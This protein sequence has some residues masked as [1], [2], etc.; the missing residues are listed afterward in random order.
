MFIDPQT[1]EVREPTPQELAGMSKQQASKGTATKPKAI[2]L[3][4]GT[5][6]IPMD[7]KQKP[8]QACVASDGTLTIDHDCQETD[9]RSQEGQQ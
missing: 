4:D 5:V 1:G 3:P 9:K 6:M 8:V 2:Q 7:G